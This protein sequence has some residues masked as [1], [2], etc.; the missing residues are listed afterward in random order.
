MTIEYTITKKC[1][2]CGREIIYTCSKYGAPYVSCFC[3]DKCAYTYLTSLGSKAKPQEK[4][5]P[6]ENRFEILDLWE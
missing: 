3:D 1:K 5:R 4:D 2:C 6:I